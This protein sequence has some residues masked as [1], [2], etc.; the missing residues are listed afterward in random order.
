VPTG[1]Q[2]LRL[3]GA[4]AA[5]EDEEAAEP[6]AGPRAPAEIENIAQTPNDELDEPPGAGAEGAAEPTKLVT[7]E[8][9]AAS[10]RGEP[11]QPATRY[12][13]CF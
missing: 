6:T 8:G 5:A 3:L 7:D 10:W 11:R 2:S 9:E 1:R 4:E 13:L 12:F